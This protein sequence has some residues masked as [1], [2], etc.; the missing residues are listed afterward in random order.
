MSNCL[1][2]NTITLTYN[3]NT[4]L[5]RCLICGASRKKRFFFWSK[6][7]IKKVE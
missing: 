4:Q 6:W 7:N 3:D 1:H 2:D 5:Q